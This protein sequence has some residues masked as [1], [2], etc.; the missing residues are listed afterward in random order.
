MILQMVKHCKA[1][2][3]KEELHFDLII[4]TGPIPGYD[5]K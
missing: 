1:A 5:R 3:D 4:I 2:F